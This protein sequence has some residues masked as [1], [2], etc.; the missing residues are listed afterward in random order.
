MYSC[1]FR[2]VA[3]LIK[4]H[5]ELTDL[6]FSQKQGGIGITLSKEHN[7]LQVV[8]IEEDGAASQTDLQRGEVLLRI[9][10]VPTTG[11][12]C[13]EAVRMLAGQPG[14][15]VTLTVK[16]SALGAQPRELR[17]RR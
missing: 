16:P 1:N 5:C 13:E 9:D 17:I 11:R 2:S 15:S 6:P 12:S 14:S 3:Y 7:G 10:G 4:A 8:A